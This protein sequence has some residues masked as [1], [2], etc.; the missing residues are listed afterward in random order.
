VIPECA[1]ALVRGW[2]GHRLLALAW[3]DVGH[4]IVRYSRL[5]DDATVTTN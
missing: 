5:P 2:A 3:P 1:Q 4:Q